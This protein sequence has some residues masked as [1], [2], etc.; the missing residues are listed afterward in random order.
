[1]MC[2]EKTGCYAVAWKYIACLLQR[3]VWVRGTGLL[4][5]KSLYIKPYT[6]S[7]CMVISLRSLL[8]D[9][10][11]C[12]LLVLWR[13]S[14][15]TFIKFI[16]DTGYAKML[17]TLFL[18]SELSSNENDGNS[19]V[20]KGKGNTDFTWRF[21]IAVNKCKIYFSYHYTIYCPTKSLGIIVNC[22]TNGVLSSA[23]SMLS[24]A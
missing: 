6:A 22:S 15:Q 20:R 2:F 5:H 3:M 11:R 10:R 17:L 13:S 16:L 12:N 19:E 9:V 7:P 24:A 21:S 23:L 4:A 1:M 18:L 8:T 14:T